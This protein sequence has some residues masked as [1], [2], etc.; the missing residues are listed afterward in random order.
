M[1][2]SLLDGMLALSSKARDLGTQLTDD[3]TQLLSRPES[4]DYSPGLTWVCGSVLE[5]PLHNPLD[6]RVTVKL[7]ARRVGVPPDWDLAVEPTEADLAARESTTIKARLDAGMASIPGATSRVAIE[8]YV[9]GA[10]RG[11][12]VGQTRPIGDR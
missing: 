7:H 10:L 1:R 12:H 2:G 6:R 4:T 3:N 8:G 11:C 5:I 9:E